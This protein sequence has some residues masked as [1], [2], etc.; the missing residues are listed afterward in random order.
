MVK[1]E[2][3]KGMGIMLDEDGGEEAN[4][5]EGERGSVKVE[6]GDR[7]RRTNMKES[8]EA[9]VTMDL[10][11]METKTFPGQLTREDIDPNINIKYY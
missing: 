11:C 2:G 5:Y 1:M 9:E 3:D 6:Q 8:G 7:R 4:G 10:P